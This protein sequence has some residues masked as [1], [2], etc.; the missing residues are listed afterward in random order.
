[1][2]EMLVDI[3]R[4]KIYEFNP[5][6]AVKLVMDCLEGCNKEQAFKIITGEYRLKIVEDGVDVE[7]STPDFDMQEWANDSIASLEDRGKE[8]LEELEAVMKRI[9]VQ[10]K[11]EI[12]EI[13]LS[14]NAL[15]NYYFNK[16]S[17]EI[18]EAVESSSR[19]A[20]TTRWFCTEC[21]KFLED[22]HEMF[23]AFSYL[24]KNYGI[25]IA[26]D[27]VIFI[28][29]EIN[30]TIQELCTDSSNA[31]NQ[32]YA[33]KKYMEAEL[34]KFI[35]EGKTIEELRKNNVIHPVDITSDTDAG[36]LS[37][38]GDY[39]GLKGAV[40]NFLHIQIADLLQMTG[41]ISVDEEDMKAD[42]WMAQN[43]W[44][45]IHH[46]EVYYDGYY[47]SKHGYPMVPLTDVQKSRIAQYGKALYN[48]R[49]KFGISKQECSV[50]KFQQ[51]DE[52]AV[53]KLFDL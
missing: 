13:E 1:M 38:E 23:I 53:R 30:Q 11:V 46:D 2:I 42:A 24:K 39:Y 52:F 50:S 41:R 48:G 6:A 26:S 4:K 17:S 51:M 35:T 14:Y 20:D 49:L 9:I 27:K 43:G 47:Q 36:W 10:D 40:A 31:V 21:R 33:K 3:A 19:L 16:D 28:C 29:S 8:L 22:C 44:V 34:D 5:G 45:K 15:F 18:I 32:A 37:P 12:V 7:E 25:E